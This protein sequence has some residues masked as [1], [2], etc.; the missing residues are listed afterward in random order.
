VPGQK[1]LRDSVNYS[2][3]IINY[4]PKCSDAAGCP[5]AADPDNTQNDHD[6]N[7]SRL[8]TRKTRQHKPIHNRS[9]VYVASAFAAA[10]SSNRS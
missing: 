1:N 6:H 4:T 10:S 2:R 7:L 3:P 9:M 5:M 8:I